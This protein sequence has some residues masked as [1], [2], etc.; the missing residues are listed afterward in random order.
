MPYVPVAALAQSL[1]MGPPRE[2]TMEFQVPSYLPSRAK[3]SRISRSWPKQ[4][5]AERWPNLAMDHGIP[6]TN[7]QKAIGKRWKMMENDRKWN[8][9]DLGHVLSFTT[10]FGYKLPGNIENL[11]V[12]PGLSLVK[13]RN[14]STLSGFRMAPPPMPNPSAKTLWFMKPLQMAAS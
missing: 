7:V 8:R 6:W 14:P 4:L 9:I 3:D 2:A 10:A 11:A 12:V 5:R 13:V 1:R